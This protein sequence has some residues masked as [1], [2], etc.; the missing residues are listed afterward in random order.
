MYKI[1]IE[2]LTLCSEIVYDDFI[3]QEDVGY[4]K[5]YE[6][7][8]DHVETLSWRVGETFTFRKLCY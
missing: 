7:L 6:Y 8:C 5:V 2:Y 4:D 1:F 3:L